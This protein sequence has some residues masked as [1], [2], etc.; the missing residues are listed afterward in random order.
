VTPRR[1][2]TQ[3]VCQHCGNGDSQLIRITPKGPG[4]IYYCVADLAA[5]A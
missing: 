2:G 3:I 1:N 4:A 5:M